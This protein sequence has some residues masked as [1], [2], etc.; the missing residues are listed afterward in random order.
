MITK[1]DDRIKNLQ[2]LYLQTSKHSQYQVLHPEISKLVS[3]KEP[4]FSKYEKER[5]EFLKDRLNFQGKT[6]LDTGGNTGYF[7]IESILLGAKKVFYY[8]GNVNHAIFLENAL[9]LTRISDK[10]F[11]KPHYFNF[12][13]KFKK[14]DLTLNL[15]V[16]HH[17]GDDYSGHTDDIFNAKKKMV[18]QMNSLANYSKYQFLQIGFN[19]KGNINLP[20]F[21]KGEKSEIIDFI[22]ENTFNN[23]ELLDV[24]ILDAS[25]QDSYQSQNEFNIMNNWSKNEFFNRPIFLL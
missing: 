8:E 16:L 24:G 21:D 23:W 22:K 2:K 13:D 11:I 20:L 25:K 4:K 3:L 10:I 7:S 15:N 17:V 5:I 6:I 19:W 18:N 9:D 1:V 12:P 14:V